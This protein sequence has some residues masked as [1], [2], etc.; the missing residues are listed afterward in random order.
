M[1]L[2]FGSTRSHDALREVDGLIKEGCA[3]VVDA[4]LAG[5]LDP[6]SYYPLVHAG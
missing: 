1:S 6:V 3:Y 2:P 5:Y 4:D